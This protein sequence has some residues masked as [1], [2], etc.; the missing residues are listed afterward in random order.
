MA[1]LTVTNAKECIIAELLE[2]P[3]EPWTKELIA[4]IKPL[5]KEIHLDDVDLAHLEGACNLV[6]EG[7]VDVIKVQTKLVA[8][9]FRVNVYFTE[10]EDSVNT[11]FRDMV[12]NMTAAESDKIKQDLMKPLCKVMKENTEAKVI[13]EATVGYDALYHAIK[14]VGFSEPDSEP[15]PDSDIMSII[16]RFYIQGGRGGA[17]AYVRVSTCQDPTSE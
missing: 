6:K 5:V 1:S 8:Q 2:N 10:K 3:K 16:E 11:F 7:F 15:E 13:L 14:Y 17:Q 4:P 9:A 12:G